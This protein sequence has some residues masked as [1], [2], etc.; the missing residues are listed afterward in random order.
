MKIGILANGSDKIGMG[1]IM[2]MSALGKYFRE[3]G[4]HVTFFSEYIEGI[5]Y[6]ETLNFDVLYISIEDQYKS[7]SRLCED[8]KI[9][10]ILADYYD[11]PKDFFEN[12]SESIL[13]I[14]MDDIYKE[15]NNCDVVINGNIFADASKYNSFK[16]EDLWIGKDYL[17]LRDEFYL[18][19]KKVFVQ[20]IRS[21]MITTGGTDIFGS[22]EYLIDTVL[23]IKSIQE[24]NVII[25]SAFNNRD[26][27]IEKYKGNSR[28]KLVENQVMSEVMIKSDVAISASGS[29]TYELLCL[30]VP[31]ASFLMIDNQKDLYKYLVN[32]DLVYGLGDV[33]DIKSGNLENLIREFLRNEVL[34]E[35]YSNIFKYDIGNGKSNILDNIKR[36]KRRS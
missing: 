5:K 8:E 14:T 25:G 31:T 12:F 15:Y 27:L 18:S 9:C 2:R 33:E 26:V 11:L 29:T 28:V 20:E 17:I 36:F 7:V 24:I 4:H 3:K 22:M 32:K 19:P 13:K 23:L 10:V 16:E 6:L 30:N 21:V 1:H 35:I 34:R